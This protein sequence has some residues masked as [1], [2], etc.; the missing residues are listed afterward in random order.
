[1]RSRFRYFVISFLIASV[2]VALMLLATRG[3]SEPAEPLRTTLIYGV[4]EWYPWALLAP[5]I[6]RRVR[7]SRPKTGAGRL[8]ILAGHAGLAAVFLVAHS[9]LTYSVSLAMFPP[10]GRSF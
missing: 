1:M 10:E 3:R 8:Q 6:D 2:P 7:R 9:A 5:F 4:V